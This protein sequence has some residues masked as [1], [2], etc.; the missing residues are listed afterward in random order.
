MNRCVRA[1]RGPCEGP[2]RWWVVTRAPGGELDS[3]AEAIGPVC[4]RHGLD[5]MAAAERATPVRVLELV[6]A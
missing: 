4:Y 5:E 3:S 2:P 6:K 1:D